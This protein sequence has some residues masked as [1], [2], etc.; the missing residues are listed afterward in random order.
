MKYE[1]KLYFESNLPEDLIIEY[2]QRIDIS[3]ISINRCIN[4]DEL[5]N[6]QLDN[7]DGTIAERLDSFLYELDLPLN[8]A[9]LIK[10]NFSCL[11]CH[12]VKSLLTVAYLVC[13]SNG[14]SQNSTGIVLERMAS[15]FK[16]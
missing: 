12:S 11:K 15:F 13:I 9:L 4:I 5:I 2:M 7:E 14:K 3:I 16:N 10:K 6:S 1:Y 8:L